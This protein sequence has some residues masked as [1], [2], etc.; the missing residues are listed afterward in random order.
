LVW[1]FV[2]QSGP[3]NHRFTVFL[4]DVFSE[5]DELAKGLDEPGELPSDSHEAALEKLQEQ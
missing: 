1:I 4:Y 3:Q 5:L 2:Y